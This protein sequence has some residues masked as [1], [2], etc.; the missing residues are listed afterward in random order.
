[1][2]LKTNRD[3]VTRYIIIT[4][5]ASSFRPV[6]D[7]TYLQNII[8]L[9]SESNPNLGKK[10][11]YMYTPMG[12]H[13]TAVEEIV[14]GLIRDDFIEKRDDGRLCLSDAD[15]ITFY[16]FLEGISGR[17][18]DSVVRRKEFMND[19]TPDEMLS[20]IHSC[21][22]APEYDRHCRVMADRVR[23]AV[24]MYESGKIGMKRAAQV[25]G[26]TYDDFSALLCNKP[27][28]KEEEDE[29]TENR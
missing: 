17:Q 7:I 4:L 10:A 21:Y 9:L 27:D 18:Y 26:M 23:H 25:S 6:R 8:F 16:R 28:E 5:G 13:S 24:S 12:P 11:R 14:N 22:P 3:I 20:L 1:M 15:A 2:T 29:D 19:L